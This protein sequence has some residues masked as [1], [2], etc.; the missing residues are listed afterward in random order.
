MLFKNDDRSDPSRAARLLGLYPDD[1]TETFTY[2][3]LDLTEQTD[4]LGRVT[5][6]F[7]DPSTSLGVALSAVEG[8]R[9][10]PPNRHARSRRQDDLS[11]VV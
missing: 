6:H 7:Y 10:R 2:S 8:R 1:T 5:R 4:R 11:S 3:R 9:L